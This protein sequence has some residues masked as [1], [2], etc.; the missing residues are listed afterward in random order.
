MSSERA[1][2]IEGPTAIGA[3]GQD[4][5][6]PAENEIHHDDVRPIVAWYLVALAGL[7]GF[8]GLTVFIAS[9]GVVPFD[10]PLLDRLGRWLTTTCWN[11]SR[12]RRRGGRTSSLS[13][14]TRRWASRRFSTSST[15]L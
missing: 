12:C 10:Q 9:H 5:S 7:I 8:V 4:R 15:A 1:G 2:P 14:R 6:V 13:A 11:C 3:P